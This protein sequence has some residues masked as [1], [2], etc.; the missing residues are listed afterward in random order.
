MTKETKSQPMQDEGAPP[1][2]R[3]Q[4]TALRARKSAVPRAFSLSSSEV[5]HAESAQQVKLSR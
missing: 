1:N 2:Q 5:A 4:L 3:L